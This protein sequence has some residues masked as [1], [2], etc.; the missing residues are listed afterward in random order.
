MYLLPDLLEALNELHLCQRKVSELK[1]VHNKLHQIELQ[2]EGLWVTIQLQLLRTQKDFEVIKISW[3]YHVIPTID[4]IK[5]F[6]ADEMQFL[7]DERFRIDNGNIQ[8]PKWVIELIILQ[9][10]RTRNRNGK[11]SHTCASQ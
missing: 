2:L 5:D 10:G 9:N 11:L 4:D 1:S 6:A 7:E 3:E 8:G